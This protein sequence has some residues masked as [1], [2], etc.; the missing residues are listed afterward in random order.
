MTV[1]PEVSTQLGPADA[2]AGCPSPARAP[3]PASTRAT[4]VAIAPVAASER[5]RFLV[6]VMYGT[7][8]LVKEA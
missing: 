1:L 5:R 7:P 6:V 4:T 2:A 3:H 8:F